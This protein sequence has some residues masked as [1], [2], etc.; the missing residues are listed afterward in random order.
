MVRSASA[1]ASSVAS[2]PTP[3]DTVT[4]SPTCVLL[5]CND[6]LSGTTSAP[7]VP[8]SALCRPTTSASSTIGFNRSRPPAART[9]VVVRESVPLVR[10]PIPAPAASAPGFFVAK[11]VGGRDGRAATAF[12]LPD[13]HHCMSGR[14][15]V[16]VLH[17][18]GLLHDSR[19]ELKIPWATAFLAVWP[20]RVRAGAPSLSFS[21]NPDAIRPRR[22]CSRFSWDQT[23]GRC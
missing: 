21:F 9:N 5:M 1:P 12:E 13:E 6:C 18:G 4:K 3:V 20:A 16:E 2:A 7:T 19:P 23:A 15:V 10:A 14:L 8:A 11:S 17:R 22:I